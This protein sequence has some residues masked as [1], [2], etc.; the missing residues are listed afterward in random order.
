MGLSGVLAMVCF[1]LAV[2][3][4]ASEVTPARMRIPSYAVWETAVFVL[5]V[6]AVVFIGLQIRPILTALDPTARVQYLWIAAAV[7][8]TVI[9][10]RIAWVGIYYAVVRTRRRY[11]G[12]HGSS[13]LPPPS[14]R[15]ALIVGWSGM[16]GIVTLAAALAL[17]I[18]TGA[19]AFPFRDLVVLTASAVVLGTLVIPGLTLGPLVRSFHLRDDDPVSREVETARDRALGAALAL[20]DGLDSEVAR[21]VRQEFASHLQ[22]G[23]DEPESQPES[24]QQLHRS[25]L[26]VARRTIL[27]MR[28][29]D[30]IGDDA[31]HQLEQEFDWIEMAGD[32]QE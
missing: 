28:A 21:L 15:G 25:A 30:E 16:R 3:R 4:P 31:F 6:L 24:H 22:P 19:T 14:F 32:P 27:E 13:P 7:L 2:A 20:L 5:N 11:A 10:V 12:R 18:Q 9:V 1:A 17:P 23:L 8:L 26:V 29:N